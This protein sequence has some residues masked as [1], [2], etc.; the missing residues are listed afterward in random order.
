MKI[1]SI[2]VG[3]PQTFK[4]N[5]RSFT[6]AIN[7][8]PLKGA[9]RVGFLN[10]EG[11]KQADLKVHGGP[12]KAVYGYGLDALDLWKKLRPQDEMSFGALGENLS[13]TELDENKIYL[14]DRFRVGSAEL[15]AVQ[16]RFPCSKLAAKYNDPK[17]LKQFMQ[18]K[19]PGVYYRVLKE[20]E[21]EASTLR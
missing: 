10:L 20:G 18:L 15:M 5:G 8:A 1:E 9:V 2:Q 13:I 21:I 6:T 3:I 16:P 19:R 17:I 12:N 7:K 14:G 4:V 11:D